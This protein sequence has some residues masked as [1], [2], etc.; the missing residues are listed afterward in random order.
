MFETINHFCFFLDGKLYYDLSFQLIDYWKEA[1]VKL[2]IVNFFVTKYQSGEFR[3]GGIDFQL[4][5]GI[6]LINYY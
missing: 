1:N 2:F 6:C 3:K 5:H 4:M